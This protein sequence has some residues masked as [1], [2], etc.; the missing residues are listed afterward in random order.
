[1]EGKNKS[2]GEWTGWKDPGQEGIQEGKERRG[3]QKSIK[4]GNNMEQQ[5]VKE[6]NRVKKEAGVKE[7]EKINQGKKR[8]KNK[9]EMKKS[10]KDG[11]K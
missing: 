6:K 2:A 5:K 1:M 8:K 10:R 7:K 11:R 9:G 3:G 4:W